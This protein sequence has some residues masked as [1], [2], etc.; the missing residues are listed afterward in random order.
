MHGAAMPREGAR[1]HNGAARVSTANGSARR[2][3]DRLR[4]RETGP[5][6]GRCR[7]RILL[8]IPGSFRE[9]LNSPACPSPQRR[10][11]ARVSSPS[12]AWM[13]DMSSSRRSSILRCRTWQAVF[14]IGAPRNRSRGNQRKATRE[15]LGVEASARKS[16]A[17]GS[18]GRM[19]HA[20]V[21][22]SAQRVGTRPVSSRVSPR[23]ADRVVE[24]K[25]TG[26]GQRRGTCCGDD[27]GQGRGT[28]GVWESM[29]RGAPGRS[30]ARMPVNLNPKQA[31][32]PGV[33]SDQRLGASCDTSVP[34]AVL[35]PA[36]P[37]S[38]GAPGRS[39]ARMPVNLNPKQA[40]D[41]GVVSDQR[42]G[43]SCDTSG[44][45]GRS[46]ARMPVN[47]NPKQ[48][49]D[50]GVVS[51][52]RLGASCDTSV[53][54]AVLF[55]AAPRSCLG[56]FGCSLPGRSSILRLSPAAC[57][58][59][60]P[61]AWSSARLLAKV[62]GVEHAAAMSG[63]GE[64]HNG[65]WESMQRGAPGRSLARMP[66]NLNPKQATDPGV[67]SDQRLGASCDTSVPLAVLFPAAP[68]S[69][70]APG[71]SLARMP[72]NLNP[73]QATDPG[74]VSDQRLGASCDT[75][76]PLAVLFPAAPRSCGAPGRSLA[77]MPVNLN[78]K[79]ATDPGVV[80]DQRLGASCDTSVP[81]AV[82]FPAAPRSC[83][84]PGRSL[85]R[86][87]VNLN[88]KQATDPGVV[89]DQRLGASC[90]TSVPLAVLFPAAPRSCGAPGRSLARMPVNLNPKQATDPGVVSDQRLGASCDT[91]VPLAVLFPAAP[92]S[93][94]APGRSLA[95]MPVNLNPK[96]ATDPGVVSDQRLGASCD[97]S[98]PL[99]VLF[100][101][102]P[103]S[104][105]APGRSLARMPVNLNP[106][107]AT[108]PGVVSDQR[109]GASCDTSV[110]LAVLFPAAPR[111]CGAPGRS[112]ARM[113]VN[114][115][116]KQAT[117]PGVVSD[118]R[119]GASCDTS[120]PLAVLFPAAPRSCG[121]PG[122][123]LARMPVNL[124]P[125]QATD[126]G[127][128]SD[129]R[130]GASCDTSVP[131]AVLFPAAPRSC[132]APGRSLARMPVN[133]N[134]K[135]A[136]DP[137]VVSD[138]RLG[139]SCDTSVPLAVFP[140]APRSC[141]APG[142]SLARMPVNLNPKQATDPGVVSD[143]RLGASCDTSVPL[144]V[145]FP[146]APRS[147]GAPGRSLAR[148]PVNLNP[149][150]AT[151]PGVVSDQ[152]LGASCDTSVPLAVLFPAAPR[153]CGA[154]GRSLARMPV[155]LNPKQA[156]DPGVVSDQRLGASCDTSVP[157]AVLFPAAPRSCGAPGRS[158]ARMPVN[159]NPKQATDPGVVSDQ[160]LGASCDTSVPLAVLFPA[161]PRSCV[162]QRLPRCRRLR[163]I[164][165]T[166]A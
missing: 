8:P 141:G 70:G 82:L 124:N 122:R 133:L 57:R 103:R 63:T 102:A 112:L 42:L 91:S 161:A 128:V 108:D 20:I 48:A 21:W 159:L 52:Q 85:A 118:Q 114:L 84:A 117:D 29:Q 126:P 26:E 77:R 125:K 74:V 90:D 45:P 5:H 27:Q 94:G 71:R 39:L 35:F 98:V 151:D 100:P 47:L 132:G 1:G 11:N 135:Q 72:V 4:S 157:L 88:P 28:S 33:V 154:P 152:R 9:G 12:S 61:I 58:P 142:R 92:R 60:A 83:G 165:T 62:S 75:S 68:R 38:C 162:R 104:C 73:K 131:L 44:A 7:M 155:N 64:G 163:C 120:V 16:V 145:L 6:D 2:H 80:S 138:Q 50:P 79:Q 109:L 89:S 129:Q 149:K 87:P 41:P 127:V 97:T 156:T 93:C 81:L 121:A 13:F 150:Q 30:L 147:C 148:M 158:L 22:E 54:L 139:A 116:P 123:S 136:T 10:A 143:Q 32:D 55:P 76:V 46:L 59:A 106:K 115:N 107:Q 164:G 140:A 78:P 65:V 113:P 31:T 53:P 18:Q 14:A 119:L 166:L 49:T 51:D 34:L 40:T 3:V 67:V 23:G 56:S 160:R 86:M 96:Q 25:D 105:G 95:R 37:R 130:L 17:E 110:P 137:G 43:A 134:P 19:G 144:A 69:C 24:R 153:S 15:V 146:A 99:A 111:S 66:V 36:A 101:A